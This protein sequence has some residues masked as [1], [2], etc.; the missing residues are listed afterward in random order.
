MSI[1]LSV[2]AIY[3]DPTINNDGL[4]YL[5]SAEYYIDGQWGKGFELWRWPFFPWLLSVIGI[6]T[7][8]S[9][10]YSAYILN[11]LLWAIVIVSFIALIKELGG[12]TEHL[13]AAAIIILVFTKI[14]DY[15]D[16]IIRD[17]GYI[18]FYLLSFLFF[19]RF[20]RENSWKNAIIWSACMIVATLFRSEGFAFLALMPLIL[21]LD[22]KRTI[23]NRLYNYLK[24][25][26]LFITASVLIF[27]TLSSIGSS[28]TNFDPGIKLMSYIQSFGG[29]FSNKVDII[30]KYV[31]NRFSHQY[32][33]LVALLTILVILIAKIVTTLGILYGPLFI[34]GL[35]TKAYT[36]RVND[37]N[38]W[39]WLIGIN[40]I[41]LLIYISINFFLTGRYVLALV[42]TMMMVT[43][44]SLIR[45]FHQW[46][47]NKLS[48]HKSQKYIYPLVILLMIYMAV[49]G[50]V[51]TGPSKKYIKEA[52]L[53]IK[54]NIA[55]ESSV[56]SNDPI[57]NYY[58][59]KEYIYPFPI[60]LS[61]AT[62]KYDYTA[63]RI[64]RKKPELKTK[65]INE[66]KTEPIKTF[67]N[68]RGDLIL[69][70]KN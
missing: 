40:I 66:I 53:W 7:S 33:W 38:V 21:L 23:K 69:L 24:A 8:L 16:Y 64:K 28:I 68:K 70:F 13:V 30:N 34:H 67:K 19:I 55:T 2:W 31:L 43:P 4:I 29:E 47:A 60:E 18:A 6:V 61:E 1:I 57:I 27:I 11:T 62:V 35:Y 39:L 12:K 32:D 25:N 41:I 42:L 54:E 56:Y 10:E 44:F 63:V 45:I 36:P 50:L 17:A 22:S 48:S 9:P 58:A 59:G 3:N 51:S 37:R 46:K 14:N 5:K 49:D 20:S 65:A 26:A 15:R 52:G